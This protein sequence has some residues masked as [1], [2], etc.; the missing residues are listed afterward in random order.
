[1][2]IYEA[3]TSG[4]EVRRRS[5]AT[6]KDILLCSWRPEPNLLTVD[7]HSRVFWVYQD[8]SF[9]GPNKEPHEWDVLGPD[10]R[11]EVIKAAEAWYDAPQGICT[12]NLLRAIENLRKN[13]DNG[14]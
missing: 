6:I 9:D 8:G 2:T 4:K 12:K 13:R 10:P 1:M 3:F 7:E 14:L 5:G 11:D